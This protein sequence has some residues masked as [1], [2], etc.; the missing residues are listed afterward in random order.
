MTT[1]TIIQNKI[2]SL[3][4]LLNK[5]A[6]WRFKQQKIVFTNGCFDL[7]HQGHIHMFMQT[8]DLG[9]KLIV[10]LN[11]DN[12]V[13]R[14]K[15]SSRPIQKQEAR[16]I[17]LASLCFIDAVVLF[18]QDTPLELITQIKPDVL[19]K[20]GDYTKKQIVGNSLVEQNGGEVVIIPTLE[21][22]ATTK[23]V[24]KILN[25]LNGRDD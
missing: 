24:A 15:G 12:S 2:F 19:A 14:L 7:L 17:I 23:I 3:D 16:A 20:G 1:T 21:E 25:N 10:G 4:K 6:I 9:D 13:T 22:Y 11:S 5:V 18:E 8:A